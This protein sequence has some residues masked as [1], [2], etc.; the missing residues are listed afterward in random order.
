MRALLCLVLAGFLSGCVG[1]HPTRFMQVGA[2][3]LAAPEAGK[4]LVNFHR[5]SA[6]GDAQ[7]CPIFDATTGKMIGNIRGKQLFQYQC[8]PGERMFIGWGE[9]KS[10]VKCSL[11]ADKVYDIVADSGIGVLRVSVS[12]RAIDKGHVKRNEVATWEGMESLIVL[13]PSPESDKYNA[14]RAKD[15][16]SIAGEFAANPT[17]RLT[18]LAADDAR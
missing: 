14:S 16:A 11:A 2:V 8:P 17:D 4:V 15:L 10:A 12:I 7:D 6:Y 9:H 18:V 13:A 1:S 3:K 5:P